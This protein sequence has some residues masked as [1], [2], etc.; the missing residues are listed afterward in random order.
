M[1]KTIYTQATIN[2]ENIPTIASVPIG[3]NGKG[4]KVTIIAN[5]HRTAIRVAEVSKR[6]KWLTQAT[7]W[8]LV[9][10]NFPIGPLLNADTHIFDGSL[11]ENEKKKQCFMM[12]ALPKT[13]ADSIAELGMKEWGSAHKLTRLDV[14]E[15]ILFRYYVQTAGDTLHEE[16][17]PAKE[18]MPL[19]VIF[20]Q[21]TGYRLLLLDDGLP[22]SAHYLS[23]HDDTKEM[24]VD[25]VWG[26]AA[27]NRVIYST[28]VFGE[29][30]APSTSC[31]AWLYEYIKNKGIEMES[32]TVYLHS[33]TK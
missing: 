16:D 6:D 20:A 19:W 5:T 32:E 17:E 28:I 13:I 29:D 15:H 18:T 1:G 7:Q 12:V 11:F 9:E 25:M 33:N 27:P 23:M 14:I 4:P 3:A 26:I 21:D 2:D 10:E 22:V 8:R 30:E 24:E 31:D